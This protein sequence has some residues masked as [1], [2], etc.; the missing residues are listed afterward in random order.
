M[1]T[2]ITTNKTASSLKIQRTISASVERVYKAW[3]DP[4]QMGKWFGCAY[5]T[6]IKVT[7]NLLVG[8]EYQV[9]MTT[10]PDGVVVTVHGVYKEVIPN[11]KLVYTWNSDSIEYP[12]AD[13]LITVEFIER[14]KGTEIVLEHKNFALENSVEGHSI[15]WT[16]A[17]NKITELL[18]EAV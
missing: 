9:Q 11:K 5:V 1:L 18:E 13:T 8:G 16:A 12:A 6:D 2:A 10:D 4:R 3:T 7:Q 17:F 14:G 15:G